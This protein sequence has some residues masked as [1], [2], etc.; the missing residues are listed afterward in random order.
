M[1]EG[2]ICPRCSASVAPHCDVCVRCTPTWTS[3]APCIHE[4][5]PFTSAGQTCRKCGQLIQTI[6]ISPYTGGVSSGTVIKGNGDP[7]PPF[8]F[9][10]RVPLGDEPRF[11]SGYM[12]PA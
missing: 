11:T 8:T 7:E 9:T 5:G 12:A 6:T 10:F 2:W 1:K 4:P 3:V